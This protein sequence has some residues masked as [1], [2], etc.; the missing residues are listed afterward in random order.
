VNVDHDLG[1]LM[2]LSYQEFVREMHVD[3]AARGY[4][5][6]GRSDGYVFRALTET[7]MNTSD[8]AERLGITKQG[9]AQIVDDMTRRGYLTSG[10]DPDDRRARLLELTDRGSAALA[11]ARSFHRRYEARL[12][13]RHGRAAVTTLRELLTATG[14]AGPDGALDARL[15]AMYL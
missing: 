15:R 7:A 12:V 3:L 14:P 8:L 5:D 10:P 13:R 1:I 11:A 2:A 6:L 9:A 4:D